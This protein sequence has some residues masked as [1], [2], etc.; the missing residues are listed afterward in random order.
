M[1]CDSEASISNDP[2]DI[3]GILKDIYEALDKRSEVCIR[4]LE[5]K[6]QAVQAIEAIMRRETLPEVKEILRDDKPEA[7]E[8]E[9]SDVPV[10]EYRREAKDA[11]VESCSVFWDRVDNM[12]LELSRC[13]GGKVKAD[14]LGECMLPIHDRRKQG[15]LKTCAF[16]D[17]E[18]RAID[19]MLPRVKEMLTA[20]GN[21]SSPHAAANQGDTEAHTE[22]SIAAAVRPGTLQPDPG[23]LLHGARAI[24]EAI[25]GQ[26]SPKA[27]RAFKRIAQ[28]EGAP[29]TWAK[30]KGKRPRA[31]ENHLKLWKKELAARASE[32][33]DRSCSGLSAVDYGRD[34]TQ[35]FT[36]DSEQATMSVRKKRKKRQQ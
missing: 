35:V 8:A 26:Y 16:A 7:E 6:D 17:V 28:E 31:F 14:R 15:R 34:G 25:E 18:R 22:D 27:W 3:R 5:R 10:R 12:I 13:H 29:I 9:D 11:T 33:A 20:K 21:D 19:V 1:T 2:S 30:S 23:R 32:N 36:G 24:F 4:E